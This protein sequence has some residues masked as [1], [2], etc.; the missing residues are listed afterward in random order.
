MRGPNY[1]DIKVHRHSCIY[2]HCITVAAEGEMRESLD[3]QDI[4]EKV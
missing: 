4:E 2:Y 1:K 3:T